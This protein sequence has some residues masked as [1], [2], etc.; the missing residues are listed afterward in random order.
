M[1]AQGSDIP[2]HLGAMP[3]SAKGI[4]EAFPLETWRPGDAVLNND[5]YSGGSHLPDMT[6]L[7]PVFDDD[8]VVGFT[9][10]R[11]H[12]PDV[13]GS[14]AGSSSVTDEIVKEGI[15]VPP[16]KI[17][18]EGTPDEGVWTLLFANVRIPED[19][20][21]DFRAQVACNARGVQRI[22]QQIA[23]YG[24]AAVRQ[25]FAETQDY[26]Q[27]MVETV[28]TEIPDGTYR[29]VH[30]LDGDGYSEDSGHGDFGISV[31]IEK[32]GAQLHFDFTGTN[33]QARGPVN[34][35]RGHGIGLLLHDSGVGGRFGAAELWRLPGGPY[36]GAGSTLVNPIYPAPVV[37]ANTETSN[38]I[39]DVLLDHFGASHARAMRLPAVTAVLV[40]LHL[41]GSIPPVDAVS[42][43]WRRLAAAW[44]HRRRAPALMGTGSIW[45]TR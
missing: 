45:A 39:V 24:G 41:A 4:I 44:V 13:G 22:E 25:I 43:I 15:R 12:W 27:R 18:R 10:S 9:A 3:F 42:S 30:H 20:I 35:V 16:V 1:V 2:V 28:L 6:L 21:G 32:R 33:G 11:V 26:S 40:S 38:R 7:T 23:R 34:A 5:P 37:A 8:G 29:A 19:R 36:N 14:A 31:K 17:I